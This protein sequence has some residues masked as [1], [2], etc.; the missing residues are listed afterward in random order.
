MCSDCECTKVDSVVEQTEVVE[1][2]LHGT[3]GSMKVEF[4]KII[5][6]TVFIEQSID[7]LFDCFWGKVAAFD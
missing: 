7:V 4:G 6:G 2:C 5:T 1:E 3:H